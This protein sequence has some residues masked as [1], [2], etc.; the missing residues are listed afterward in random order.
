MAEEKIIYAPY[1]MQEKC[2][3]IING[4]KVYDPRWW[5]NIWCRINWF[6]HFKERKR[7]K[8][9]S[10]KKIDAKYYCEFQS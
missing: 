5:V 9:I 6:F 10:Q 7:W 1:V 3:T 4:I 2:P 8:E